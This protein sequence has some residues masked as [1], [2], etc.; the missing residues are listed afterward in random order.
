MKKRL[1]IIIFALLSALSL[2]AQLPAELSDSAR[3]YLITCEPGEISYQRFGHSGIRVIDGRM[4]IMFNWGVFSFETPNFIGRFVLGHTDYL[5]GVY[6]TRY[7]LE[8]YLDRGTAV[9]QH[10]LNLTKKEKRTLWTLLA[11]NY[12]PENRVYRYNFIFDNCATRV[13]NI[14]TASLEQST[15]PLENDFTGS[16]YRQYV[17]SYATP[18]T[19]LS[20]GINLVF[21]SEADSPINYRQ[22]ASFPIETMNLLSETATRLTVNDSDSIATAV[23][24]LISNP[25]VLFN[26]DNMYQ[27]NH[28][29]RLD[30]ALMTGLPIVLLLLL[31]FLYIRLGSHKTKWLTEIILWASVIISAIII[32]LWGFSTHPLVHSN[33]NILWCNPVNAV[34]AVTLLLH[35]RYWLK[36]ILSWICLLCSICFFFVVI[37]EVQQ[38]TWPQ[39]GWYA[40]VV[41]CQM[42]IARTYTKMLIRPSHHHHRH[43][44]TAAVP[45]KQ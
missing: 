29:N 28:Y 18:D 34:L 21:G 40:L 2:K 36:R 42:L 13:Y 10:N 44:R 27:S 31:L 19:W 45:D 39:L 32:F 30:E 24:P 17:N 41:M 25:Q 15:C 14:I 37:F 20:L 26:S 3:F 35:R 33:Y 9:I 16:T 43:H 11:E 1:T 12:L 6:E 8:S 23:V 38:A 4:D 5:L 7:F 22:A